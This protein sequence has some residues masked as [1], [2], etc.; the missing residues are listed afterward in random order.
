MT[1]R[2][3]DLTQLPHWGAA[4]RIR[5]GEAV[6]R[7]LAEKFEPQHGPLADMVEG[8]T[9]ETPAT[10]AAGVVSTEPENRGS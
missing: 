9:G 4:I 8:P 2:R 1:A 7:R 3:D 6:A 5:L 10:P